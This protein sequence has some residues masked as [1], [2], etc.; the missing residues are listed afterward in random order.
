MSTRI[1]ISFR[2]CDGLGFGRSALGVAKTGLFGNL[3]QADPGVEKRLL[4]TVRDFDVVVP[5]GSSA[6]DWFEDNGVSAARIKRITI[7]VDASRFSSPVADRPVDIVYV[8]RLEPIKDLTLLLQTVRIIADSGRNIRLRIVGKGSQEGK[9]RQVSSDLGL[10]DFVEFVGFVPDV[11]GEVGQAKCFVLTSKSEGV[12][13]AMIEAMLGGAVPVVANVGDLGDLVR[14]G[15]NGFL[16]D[17]R[18][19]EEF[20]ACITD[21]LADEHRLSEYSQAA[22]NTGLKYDIGHVAIKWNELLGDIER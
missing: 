10:D 12:S 22:Y 14:N 11:S 7:A 5:M 9:L 19:P 15:E 8:G 4:R 18:E 1:A 3:T 17:S 6:V 2:R 16:V 13:G 20:A 21:L